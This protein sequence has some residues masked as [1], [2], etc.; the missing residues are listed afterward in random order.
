MTPKLQEVIK[1][2]QLSN[3]ELIDYLEKELEKNPFLEYEDSDEKNE[4]SKSLTDNYNHKTSSEIDDSSIE[5]VESISSQI[6]STKQFGHSNTN[7]PY[8]DSESQEKISLQKHLLEQINV[9]FSNSVDRLIAIYILDL[10]DDSG[11]LQTSIQKIAET[12]GCPICRVNQILDTLQNFDPPGIFA[13]N[14]SECL[15]L[16]LKENNRYDSIKEK[17]LENLDLLAKRK[18]DSLKHLCGVGDKT[19]MNMIREVKKLNPKPAQTFDNE[20]APPLIPDV[21]V[22]RSKRWFLVC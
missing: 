9:D 4:L 21:F 18:F 5:K 2:L 7:P 13:R 8:P 20:V 17:L 14:L 11:Y 12:L 22:Y 16:Q 6:Q 10:L 3:L 15:A 19:L 1:L